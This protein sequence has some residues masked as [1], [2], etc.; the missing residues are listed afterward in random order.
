[1]KLNRIRERINAFK[2][3]LLYYTPLGKCAHL[4]KMTFSCLKEYGAAYTAERI[5][6]F[7]K[8]KTQNKS[9]RSLPNW[10]ETHSPSAEALDAQRAFH[11]DRN[12]LFSIIVPLH[13]TPEAFLRQTLD[14][15]TEQTC[16][17]WELCIADRSDADHGYTGRIC[18]EYVSANKRIHYKKQER[19]SGTSDALNACLAMASGDYIAVLDA[20]DVLAPSALFRMTEAVCSSN[21]DVIYTDEADFLSPDIHYLS[22]IRFKPDFAIDNL[23]ANPYIS[24]FTA[25][26]RSLLQKTGGY[27]SE[28]DGSRDHDLLLRIAAVTDKFVHIPEVLYF[29]RVYPKAAALNADAKS[30]EAQAGCY[31]VQE[32]LKIAGLEA[33]V[34]SREDAPAIYRIRYALTE[35]PKVSI[36]IPTCDQIYY[37]K[38]C[39]ESVEEKTTYGNY[40]V[41]LVENNSKQPETFAFYEEAKSKWRNVRVIDWN[42]P[43]NW[44]AI[45][46]FGAKAADGKYLL[47]LNNDTEIITPDWIEEMLMYAQRPD[48]GAVGAMLYFPD[49]RIQHAGIILRL[50]GDIAGHAFYNSARGEA[51]YMGRLL[52]AQDMSAVTGACVM[53]SRK[54]WDETGGLDEAL[55][56]A[57]N[58]VDFCMRIRAAGYLI[59]WTP[60]AE[61]YH[62]ESRSRG[63][64]DTPKK[65][66]RSE[67]ERNIFLSRWSEKLSCG[68]P[69]FNKNLSLLYSDF[70]IDEGT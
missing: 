2:I 62:F 56:V 29:R 50:G 6:R 58:D 52:Y 18:R 40:E 20:G 17:G 31:A 1:M 45:N 57:Y 28:C 55:A 68:D 34:E 60:Y 12:V 23:R 16:P 15:V 63:Y 9:R 3:G 37:L 35:K 59:V 21:A 25:F 66:Q 14:S 26:K 13:N 5:R 70:R 30:A 44:S 53:V 46:N 69:Y 43:W 7:L 24:R 27:R 11:F 19:D 42:G 67:K 8:K 64:D 65:I 49:N 22:E 54:V 32:S 33:R 47:L 4:A 61:L 39:L 41:L 10:V 36:I 38:K 48:V 51:G